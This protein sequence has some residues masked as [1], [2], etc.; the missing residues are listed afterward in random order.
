M[1]VKSAGQLERVIGRWGLAALVLNSIIGS[2]I[3]GLP[4]LVAARL[5]SASTYAYFLA[6][7]GMGLIMACFAEVASRFT[8][9]GGPYLYAREAF[10]RF[11]GIQ[12]GWLAWLV[13]LTAAGAN[14]N[15]FVIYLGEFWPEATQP[16]PR[17]TILTLI[18]GWLA[19]VNLL[20]V[21]SGA[22]LSS[23]FAAAKLAP[24][25]LFIL[26]GLPRIG[27]TQ[28]LE[29]AAVGFSDWM[30][31]VLVLVFAFGGFEAALIPLSEA[32]D[33]QRD[34]PFALLSSLGLC[35]VMYTLIHLVVLGVL[36][37]PGAEARPLAAAARQFMGYPGAALIALGAMVSVFGYLSSQML[38]APRLTYA[39]AEQRD[40]APAF[41]WIHP[42]FK[43][44]WFS[45]LAFAVLLWILSVA[46][47]FKWN[48]YLS[49]VS[50]LFTYGLVCAAL[51]RLRRKLPGRAA[52]HLRWGTSF[53]A[54]G[55]AFS[56]MLLAR[57]GWIEMAIIAGTMLLAWVNWLLA[58]RLIH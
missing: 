50:R 42:R 45:I 40:F 53:A 20:G 44:P 16:L 28:T 54:L 7:A 30:E 4:S 57:M 19:S 32:R 29:P 36:T 38:N 43:T 6:A 55:V 48:V 23:F 17:L 22:R 25:L 24:L 21:R 14:A 34:A 13:R 15:L 37:N 26:I 49:A 31:A 10:G 9:A 39:L 51:P 5:G 52:F 33:P 8:G 11:V 27:Q 2:G 56:L 35:T 47:S 3:F 46:G 58:R 1:A 12:M 18:I 41:G